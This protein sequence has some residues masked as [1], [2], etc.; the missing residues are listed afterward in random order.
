MNATGRHLLWLKS[1]HKFSTYGGR[2]GQSARPAGVPKNPYLPGKAG[3]WPL[4]LHL[5]GPST[6]DVGDGGMH[7]GSS[8]AL[9]GTRFLAGF[10]MGPHAVR[11]PRPEARA[12]AC[13]PHWLFNLA[14][15]GAAGSRAQADQG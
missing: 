14:F 11:V 1:G 6:L 15:P 13:G 4:E 8:R 3:A 2:A 9:S 12:W 5:L 10:L 7:A